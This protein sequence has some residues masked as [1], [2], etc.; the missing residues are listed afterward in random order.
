MSR[1]EDNI[2]MILKET[3][4]EYAEGINLTQGMIQW[5]DLVN[6]VSELMVSIKYDDFFTS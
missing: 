2:K 6:T 3:V 1:W 5:R 4:C